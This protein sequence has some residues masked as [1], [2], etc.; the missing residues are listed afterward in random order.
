[1][2]GMAICIHWSGMAQFGSISEGKLSGVSAYPS[3]GLAKLF[4]QAFQCATTCVLKLSDL[5]LLDE[6]EWNGL[7]H[8]PEAWQSFSIRA[9]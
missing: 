6:M 3:Y 1:M 8:T 5:R 7:L 9:V 2:V 4:S